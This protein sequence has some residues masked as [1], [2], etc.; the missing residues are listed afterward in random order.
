MS[1]VDAMADRLPH[2]FRD[3]A[4]VRGAASAHTGGVLGVPAVQLEVVDEDAL[5]VHLAHWFGTARG[6][7]EAAGLA[8]V[9]DIPP[10]PW[11]TLALFRAWLDSLRDSMLN[12]GAVSVRG[13]QQFVES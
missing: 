6:F 4:L 2:L 11:H 12:E 3:G 8:A 13:L 10:E 7:D 5:E 9:L 1:R